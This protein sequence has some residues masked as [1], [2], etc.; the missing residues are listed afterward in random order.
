MMDKQDVCRVITLYNNYIPAMCHSPQWEFCAFGTTDGIDVS[1]NILT[2][3]G[4]KITEVIGK[5]EEKCKSRLPGQYAAQRIYVVRR[6]VLETERSF[7]EGN[8]N[9]PFFFFCRIQCGR[10]KLILLKDRDGF[11]QEMNQVQDVKGITYLTYDNS[12][13]F[14]VIRSMLYEQG[15]SFINRLHQNINLLNSSSQQCSLKNSFTTMAMRYSWINDIEKNAGYLEEKKIDTVYI[16]LMRRE[17]GDI[18]EI[19]NAIKKFLGNVSPVKQP[20]L[21]TD[22]VI[23]VLKSV[24]WKSF[25]SLYHSENGILSEY[26]PKSKYTENACGVVTQICAN[27][28][29][30]FEKSFV[31]SKPLSGQMDDKQYQVMVQK[32]RDKAVKNNLTELVIICN[33]L[34][35]FSD[36]AFNDYIFFPLLSVF[37]TLLALI[38]TEKEFFLDKEPFFD[39]LTGFCMYVQNTILSDRHVTQTM[40][41][42]VKLYDIP[43][44]LN[45]FYNAYLYRI[46]NFLKQKQECQYDFIAF[47]GMGDIV[48]VKELYKGTLEDRRLLKVEIPEYS[49][50]KVHDMMIILAHETAHYVGRIFRNRTERVHYVVTSYAHIYVKYITN[51]LKDTFEVTETLKQEV[52][53]RLVVLL[54]NVLKREK[55]SEYL[56]EK[57]YPQLSEEKFS[58]KDE[59]K[60]EYFS[61]LVPNIHDAM[62]D[63]VI[64]S[65][66][67]LFAP[68]CYTMSRDKVQDMLTTVR[69]KSMYFIAIPIRE[70]TQTHSYEVLE[71]LQVLFEESFADVMSIM[72]LQLDVRDYING[73]LDSAQ[74]QNM[75]LEQLIHSDIMLRIAS[76]VGCILRRDEGFEDW[77]NEIQTCKDEEDRERVI[78]EALWLLTKASFD[79]DRISEEDYENNNFCAFKNDDFILYQVVEYLEKC[80]NSFSGEEIQLQGIPAIREIFKTFTNQECTGEQQI[81]T[82]MEFIDSYR[83]DLLQ[84]EKQMGK[85]SDG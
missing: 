64:Y 33:A 42:N 37:D 29:N 74:Y 4:Q 59:E 72:I 30:D 65:L 12:D 51:F 48:S 22:D 32:L 38:E 78:G 13:L 46:S 24:N 62:N 44:K 63:I 80:V 26:N 71:K 60:T 15:M 28:L 55:E 41:F 67:T 35:K 56:S 14:V 5:Y 34:P 7:W 19:E 31:K 61:E 52:E 23:L 77:K 81:I 49:F 75:E 18:S 3:E 43:V 47:P 21:G 69:D 66:S 45:A 40:G 11:E 85:M 6:D 79:E 82:M 36:K 57:K 53:E 76:V 54:F 84:E 2:K 9:M 17:G 39:F 8:D 10:E 50:Y 73:L 25:L 1:D 27:K 16:K 83:E 68:I 20:V 70:N 58:E